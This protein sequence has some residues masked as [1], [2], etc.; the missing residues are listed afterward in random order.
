MLLGSSPFLLRSK[1]LDFEAEGAGDAGAVGR[2]GA[3]TIGDVPLLDVLAR[4]AHRAGRVLEQRLLLGG[5]H[6]AEKIARLLPVITI[7]AMIAVR[8]L[9]PRSAM[10]LGEIGL[11]VPQPVAVGIEA[12]GAA[13][14]A[15]GAHLAVAM[16]ALERA[17]RRVDRDVVEVDAKPVA[18]RVAIGKEPPWS[19]LS[20]EKPM[21]GTM[22]AGANAACSTLA[23]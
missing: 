14:I 8:R 15:V 9:T 5:C 23:K 7:D 3:E 2:I 22:L 11:I 19:I 6:Q 17:L 10:A 13:K 4:I 12:E 20:G 18:L 21:P 1:I 16:I